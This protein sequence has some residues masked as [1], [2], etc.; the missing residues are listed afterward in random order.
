MIHRIVAADAPTAAGRQPQP[1]EQQWTLTF[2]HENGDDYVE[3]VIGKRGREALMAM[4]AQEDTD[5]VLNRGAPIGA[6]SGAPASEGSRKE[7]R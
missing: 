7:F 5:D 2:P 3:I 4:L 6:C 1:G